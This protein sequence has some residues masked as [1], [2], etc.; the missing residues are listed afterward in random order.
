MIKLKFINQPTKLTASVI[1]KLTQKYL[2]NTSE[3]VWKKKYITTPLLKMSFG[4]CCFCETNVNE[5]SKYMEVEHFHPK[6]LYPN[7]VV[8]WNNLLP[9]C[10]RCNGKKWNHDTKNIPIIHPAIDNPKEHLELRGYRFYGLTDLGKRTVGV[11][12]LNDKARLVDVRFKIGDKIMGQLTLLLKQTNQFVISGLIEDRNDIVEFLRN[13]LLEGVKESPFSATVATVLL[14]NPDYVEI[15][16][17]F[18]TYKLWNDEF[19]ELE[20]QVRYCALI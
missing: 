2:G 5:E 20:E 18:I 7:E 15:K 16:K 10:K 17:L 14:E 6:S 4:K 19:I 3:A 8:S 11:V 9:I 12:N 13:L 1:S